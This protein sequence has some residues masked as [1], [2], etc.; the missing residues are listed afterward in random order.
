[1]FLEISLIETID[2]E[3]GPTIAFA[4]SLFRGLLDHRAEIEL[5]FLDGR[6]LP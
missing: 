5:L 6:F 4:I 1:M 3:S 2:E